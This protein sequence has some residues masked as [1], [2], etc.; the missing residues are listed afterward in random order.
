MGHLVGGNNTRGAPLHGAAMGWLCTPSPRPT[1]NLAL[2]VCLACRP[3][4]LPWPLSPGA[5]WRGAGA[6]SAAGQR[7][8][9]PR[10]RGPPE[11][12]GEPGSGRY[13]AQAWLAAVAPKLPLSPL[14]PA[15]CPASG[16]CPGCQGRAR[17]SS[18]QGQ[19]CLS[20]VPCSQVCPC[21]SR[22]RWLSP[23]SQDQG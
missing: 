9:L 4:C 13:V 11:G 16:L 18:P 21:H 7:P 8:A 1:P 12:G 6:D 23:R 15:C 10:H 17:S 5:G 14:H 20:S 2:L 22:G 19:R 3:H